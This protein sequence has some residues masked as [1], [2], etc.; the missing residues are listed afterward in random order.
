M[1]QGGLGLFPP[2]TVELPALHLS[3]PP[4]AWHPVAARVRH[5][6]GFKDHMVE[7]GGSD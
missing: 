1:P 7:R 6:G 5:V 2:P 3:S 4:P